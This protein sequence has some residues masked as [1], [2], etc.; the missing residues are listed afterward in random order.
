VCGAVSSYKTPVSFAFTYI[1]IHIHI[2]IL[3]PAQG[4][5]KLTRA[6]S[7]IRTQSR[8]LCT[9]SVRTRMLEQ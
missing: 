6:R 5:L 7:H 9:H 4:H 2:H 3:T 8:S 1:H